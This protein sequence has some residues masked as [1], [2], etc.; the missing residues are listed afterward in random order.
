MSPAFQMD[1]AYHEAT[2]ALSLSLSLSLSVGGGGGGGGGTATSLIQ[3]DYR[4]DPTSI[5]TMATGKTLQNTHTMKLQSCSN[6]SPWLQAK[7][8]KYH[9]CNGTNIQS[10][11]KHSPWQQTKEVILHLVTETIHHDYRTSPMDL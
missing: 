6:V 5:F 1:E 8:Y 10:Y 4:P 2:A 11:K 9:Y 3:L 7:S